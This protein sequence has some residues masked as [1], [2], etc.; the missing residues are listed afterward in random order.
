MTFILMSDGSIREIPSS[1]TPAAPVPTP[2]KMGG[3]RYKGGGKKGAETA[4]A[5]STVEFGSFT[6][7]LCKRPTPKLHSDSYC[8]TC[9]NLK[10]IERQ[11]RFKAACVDHCGGSCQ[12]GCGESRPHLLVFLHKLKG[13]HS[14]ISRI[15]GAVP[16]SEKV[17][18]ELALCDMYCR[19]CSLKK[20]FGVAPSD[21]NSLKGICVRALGSCCRE[22]GY[23]SCQA[24]L[25]FHHLEPAGKLITIGGRT[26]SRAGAAGSSSSSN[27]RRLSPLS[28]QQALLE[29]SKCVLVCSNCHADSHYRERNERYDGFIKSIEAI[30]ESPEQANSTDS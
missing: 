20:Q 11:R 15:V 12:G 5:V 6:C 25:E 19:N 10:T 8:A 18:R 7:S 3:A 1:E 28:V 26:K 23:N 17:R 16:L 14:R 21:P 27:S 2:V 9:N 30:E 29:A 4:A 13:S 24:A 22:C